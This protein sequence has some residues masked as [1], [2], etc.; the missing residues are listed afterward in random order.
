M[1]QLVDEKSKA[2]ELKFGAALNNINKKLGAL[3]VSQEAL[4]LEMKARAEKTDLR[5]NY[6]ETRFTALE[7]RMDS[8]F[9]SLA[10][11]IEE[12]K[13]NNALEHL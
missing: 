12:L 6:L 13:R 2:I 8:R 3:L 4:R 5:I 9:D 10:A 7:T 1:N 11:S